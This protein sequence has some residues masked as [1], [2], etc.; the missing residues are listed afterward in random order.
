MNFKFLNMCICVRVL[1][2]EQGISAEPE[3]NLGKTFSEETVQK[4]KKFYEEDEFCQM[5]EGRKNMYQNYR[6]QNL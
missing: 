6:L 1:K 2:T 3:K 5:Y 4:W